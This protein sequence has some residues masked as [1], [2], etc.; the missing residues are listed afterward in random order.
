MPRQPDSPVAAVVHGLLRPH[1]DQL[2]L[3]VHLSKGATLAV[4]AATQTSRPVVLVAVLVVPVV[5]VRQQLA[6]LAELALVHHLPGQRL[7]TAVVAA[8]VSAWALRVRVATVLMVAVTVEEQVLVLQEQQILV[9]V[10]V[11]LEIRPLVPLP[12]EQVVRALLSCATCFPPLQ[13]PIFSV[14][15]TQAQLLTT[16]HQLALCVSGV[17]RP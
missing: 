14:P 6:V 7:A 16:S 4:T 12:V 10:A 13:H 11:A 2:V 9:A 1:L 15:M 8:A 5:L 17:M 3:A